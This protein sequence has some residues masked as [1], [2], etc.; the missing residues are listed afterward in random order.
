VG[1]QRMIE[2]EESYDRAGAVT[3]KSVVAQ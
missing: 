1:L 3:A 2:R